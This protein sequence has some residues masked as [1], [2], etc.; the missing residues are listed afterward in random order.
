MSSS[1]W[2]NDPSILLKQDKLN[3]F[4]PRKE[5][6]F[7]DKINAIT[8]L[9]ILLTFLGYL[10]TFS[11]RVLLIGILPLAIIVVLYL[12][13][14]R[15]S[16]GKQSMKE[17]FSNRLPGVFPRYT[18]PATYEKNEEK[19]VKPTPNNPLMNVLLPEI[20]YDPT[21]KGAAPSFNPVVEKEINESV[22]E[23]VEKPFDNPN[24]NKKLYGNIGDELVF[25]RSMLQYNSVPNTVIPSDQKAYLEFLYGTLPSGKD[26]D[27]F[28]LEKIAGGAYD[29]INP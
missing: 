11:F 19:F 28:A 23:F 8:R 1:F 16:Q 13:Q 10:I 22:K 6:P 2:I 5:M 7:E 27:I 18:N 12:I 20:K 24:I 4:W 17:L 25:N 26:G 15:K 3:E 9:V 29:Y 21:R 14:N